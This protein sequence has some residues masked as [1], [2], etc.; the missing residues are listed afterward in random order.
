LKRILYIDFE[1]NLKKGIREVGYLLL[2]NSKIISSDEKS[3]EDAIDFLFKLEDL[4]LKYIFAHNYS[5]EKNLI[6]KYLPYKLNKSKNKIIK[7]KW[8]D[9]L[10]I[11]RELY[12]QLK[13]YDLRSLIE[14]F[15]DQKKLNVLA[16]GMC[17]PNRKTYHYPMFDCLCVYMLIQRI[18][19]TIDLSH[20]HQD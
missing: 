20:F 13:K 16:N 9:T 14:T 18:E 19:S 7:Y 15:I 10:V 17:K 5:I 3:D 12:P 4:N 6:K 8:L 2:E 1:G 11:Y